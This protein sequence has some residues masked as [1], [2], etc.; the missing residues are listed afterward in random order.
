[1]KQ[2]KKNLEIPDNVRMNIDDIITDYEFGC[3][4]ETDPSITQCM[5]LREEVGHPRKRKPLKIWAGQNILLTCYHRYR[6]MARFE[7]HITT[8][9]T[10][11]IDLPNRLM[12]KRWIISDKLAE[13]PGPTREMILRGRRYRFEIQEEKGPVQF[14]FPCNKRFF[15]KVKWLGWLSELDPNFQIG[16]SLAREY[17]IE[18]DTMLM[19][20]WFAACFDSHL[21]YKVEPW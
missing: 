2:C 16:I 8:V 5:K 19:N 13:A 9:R 10:L 4:Q 20:C 7:Y 15:K 21:A 3:L 1:M 14:Q 17:A 11:Q 6:L 18:L 12:A